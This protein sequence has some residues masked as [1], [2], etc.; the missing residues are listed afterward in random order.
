MS[1]DRHVAFCE[2]NLIRCPDCGDRVPK[3]EEKSHFER[4][5]IPV[6]CECGSTCPKDMLD[7]HKQFDCDK[8]LEICQYCELSF[9]AAELAKHSA[10]CGARTQRCSECRGYVMLSD[11][12]EHQASGCTYKSTNSRASVIHSCSE[13]GAPFFSQ[14]EMSR[15]FMDMHTAEG[16]QRHV[17]RQ[18]RETRRLLDELGGQK[19]SSLWSCDEC[20]ISFLSSGGLEAHKTLFHHYASGGDDDMMIEDDDNN[21]I[22]D[23]VQQLSLSESE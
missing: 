17:E 6:T 16:I 9:S 22:Y 18:E 3:S 20:N 8:R 11:M 1:Y 13:C 23:K 4:F 15:H 5:H 14:D 10:V 2:R 12:R 19:S 7:T 21:S